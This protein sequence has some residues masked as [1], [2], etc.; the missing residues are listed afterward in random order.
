MA[1]TQDKYTLNIK[2]KI[3]KNED[4][5]FYEIN[6]TYYNLDYTGLVQLEQVYADAI[7]KTTK[8]GQDAA[9]AAGADPK[10]FK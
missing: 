2:F 3:L 6:Q 7:V 5:E 8:F 1:E 4:E 10:L 9:I